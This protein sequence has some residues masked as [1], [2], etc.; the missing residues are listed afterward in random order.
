MSELAPIHQQLGRHEARLDAHERRFD[1]VKTALDE[2]CK[3]VKLLV[4]RD[5][6]YR[7]S[8]RSIGWLGRVF[9]ISWPVITAGGAYLLGRGH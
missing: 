7:G 3:D 2:I 6:Q 9:E 1:D 5:N 8:A 4:A